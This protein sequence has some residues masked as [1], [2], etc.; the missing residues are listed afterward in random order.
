MPSNVKLTPDNSELCPGITLDVVYD[1]TK[2]IDSSIFN[3]NAETNVFLID[4]KNTDYTDVY[5]WKLIAQFQD[6]HPQIIETPFTVVLVDYCENS[7]VVDPGQASFTTNP[8]NYFYSGSA[9][10]E[11]TSF[12]VTPPEC[13]IN[14]SCYMITGPS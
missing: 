10:F 12:T 9:N 4:T 2:S 13:A 7:V 11:L 3:F 14:Y 8:P 6:T 5:Q 1:D